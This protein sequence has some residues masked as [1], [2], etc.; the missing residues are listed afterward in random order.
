MRTSWAAVKSGVRRFAERATAADLGA[1]AAAL[2]YNFMFAIFPL[3]LFLSA[4]LGLVHVHL[5]EALFSGPLGT[6]IPPNVLQPVR[7]ALAVAL[8]DHSRTAFGLGLLGFVAGMSGAFRQMIDAMNHAFDLPLPRR[9]RAWTLYGTSAVL[10]VGVGAL[11]VAGVLLA[12]LGHALV[13]WAIGHVLPRP[14]LVVAL[15]FRWGLTLFLLLVVLDVVYAYGPDVRQP[16]RWVSRG[17]AVALTAWVALSLGFSLYTAHFNTYNAVYGTL[18]GIILLL[19]YLYL[20]GLALL[21]G[22]VI[23]ALSDG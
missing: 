12:I 2:A 22:A 13:Y 19:L 9:R 21:L 20:C 1:Y 6:L 18:G 8:R 4:L 3:L 17:S 23:N 14:F 15:A 10:G 16:F 7:G 5:Q 11:L